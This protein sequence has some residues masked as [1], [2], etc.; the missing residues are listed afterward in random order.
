MSMRQREY[1]EVMRREKGVRTRARRRERDV[2]GVAVVGRKS[3]INF[4]TPLVEESSSD[5]VYK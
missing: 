1:V 5:A 3:A 4:K 2:R